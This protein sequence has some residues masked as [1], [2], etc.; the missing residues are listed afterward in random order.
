[1]MTLPLSPSQRTLR[2]GKPRLVSSI[3]CSFDNISRQATRKTWLEV[4]KRANNARFRTTG[5]EAEQK[6]D[7]L[8]ANN[9]TPG[10][11]HS[12]SSKSR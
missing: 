4:V 11:V 7:I 12:E 2:H 9:D 6:A 10:V 3:R 5:G 8:Q 1:M